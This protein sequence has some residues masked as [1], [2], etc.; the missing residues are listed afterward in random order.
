MNPHG[1]VRWRGKSAQ[2]RASIT[3]TEPDLFEE[4]QFSF[5]TISENP[6]HR[7]VRLLRSHFWIIAACI[8]VSTLLSLLYSARQPRLYRAT[9]NVAIYRDS[10]AGPSLG[11][12]FGLG[13]G[14]LDDYSVSLETQLRILQSRTLALATVHKL[15]LDRDAEFLREAQAEIAKRAHARTDPV[16]TDILSAM[17]DVLLSGVSVTPVKQTRVVE[18]SFTGPIPDLDAK[19]V[20]ALVDGF[21]DDS[22]RSRYEAAGRSAK[23]LSGQLSDLRSK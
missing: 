9:S 11:K 6:V 12:T 10:D 3:D 23:F 17:A 14:D 22:I 18:V 20:N 15:G 5:Q 21:I 7:T 2:I 1:L 19:I 4:R 8:S 16:T 13:G